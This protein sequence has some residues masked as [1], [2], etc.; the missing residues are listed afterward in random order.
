MSRFGF[1]AVLSFVL[2]IPAATA[3]TADTAATAATADA[4]AMAATTTGSSDFTRGAPGIG[5]PYFP[6]DGNGGYDVRSYDLDVTYDPATD[7]LT[8]TATIRAH[9]T[10]DLSAF[11]LDLVGMDVR[12]VV[13]DGRDATWTR[14]AGEMTVVP[15]RGLR[16]RSGFRVVV[17]YSGVPQTLD[18]FGGSSGFMRTEDGAV[19]IGQPHV[20]ATWFPANDHPI[21]KASYRIAITVPDGLEAIS[22]GLLRRTTS[23]DGWS[24]W[25]WDAREPMSS[26]LAFMAIGEFDVRE[27]RAD[28]IRFWDALDER[29][30][31]SPAPRTG[32]LAAISQAGN[33]AYKRLTRSVSVPAAGA[34]LSFWV[35]RATETDWDFMVVEARP[36]GTDEWTTLPDA[37]GHATR[38]TG[39]L[40]Q[41]WPD[42][43]PFLAHYLTAT[44]ES[45]D[46]TGTTGTWWAASG[47]SDGFEQWVVDL[48]DYAGG[49]V[50]VSIGYVSDG[51]VALPG[52]LIDDVVVSAG[53]GTTSFE[54]EG[55]RL[56]GW[57]VAG[58]PVESGP[59]ENDWIVGTAD[60]VPP[61]FGEVAQASLARQ[62]EIIGFLGDLFGRYPFRTS[63]GVVSAHPALGFALETQ[64]R[65]VYARA[66][67][68]DSVNGDTV[69][70]HELAHQW[71]GDL[72]AVERWQHIWLNEGF[73]TYAEWLWLEREDVVSAQQIFED[74]AQVPADDPLWELVIGDPGPERLFDGPVYTRGAMTLHA[75]RL[76]V[77]DEA[78]FE[79]LRTWIRE[80]R[81]GHVTTDEFVAVAEEVSGHDL[82][83]FFDEWLFTAG[84]PASLEGA[85]AALRATDADDAATSQ[86]PRSLPWAR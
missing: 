28:G 9:A 61:S 41:Y 2:L 19:V 86:L 59:N 30:F 12:S 83:A 70:V 85:G 36:V 10:Q 40:C 56:D 16:D 84:K 6:L 67:F 66:F 22:N 68:T 69:V 24:T 71:T 21:D 42:D 18:E 54:D 74:V 50:E 46:P 48:S 29:L 39:S 80:Q 75:L 53:E 26:Y 51:S 57:V 15:A 52:L 4:A 37:G 55:D 3:A 79:I 44:D 13:V 38:S 11:N 60:D 76:E 73:A 77:G 35:D 32:D 27:Y 81:G 34:T 65:P 20:A 72:L 45:C 23:D 43:H 33:A 78:F 7:R 25:R 63:G 47:E 8:A 58:P 64:T 82:D 14:D 5:D 62:P 31:S 17:E 1:A 49:A